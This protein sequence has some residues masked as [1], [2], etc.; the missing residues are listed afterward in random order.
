MLKRITLLVFLTLLTAFCFISCGKTDDTEIA[1]TRIKVM[2]SYGEGVTVTGE[3]PVLVEPGTPVT[4]SVTLD[5]GY[6]FTNLSRGIYD[7]G[8]VTVE[9]LYENTTVK[10][11]AE[12]LDIGKRCA[13]CF[14][15]ERD[16]RIDGDSFV[17]CSRCDN[18]C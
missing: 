14:S 2:L 5:D 7:N 6:V 16:I 17:I 1:D 12:K 11:F 3:N 8:T 9:G 15:V 10:L 13:D 18:T 4:F